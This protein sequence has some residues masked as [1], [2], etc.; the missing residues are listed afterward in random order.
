MLQES[1][2]LATKRQQAERTMLGVLYVDL[3]NFKGIND[4]LGH[5]AGDALLVMV[6]ERLR[7]CT[8]P[9]DVVA[10][11]GGDEFVVLLTG[12]AL[13]S[14]AESLARRVVTELATPFAIEGQEVSISASVGVAVQPFDV[15]DGDLLRDADIAMY[16]AKF[17][18]K[19]N[20]VCF[21]PMLR[22]RIVTAA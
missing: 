12:L 5:A 4:G 15:A 22:D 18:G 3:D 20:L 10:R 2:E 13:E 14:D 21:D 7:G 19:N 8:R 6:A 1:T 11:L 17:S 16:N 9:S